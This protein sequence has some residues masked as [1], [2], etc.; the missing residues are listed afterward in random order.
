MNGTNFIPA[1]VE[2]MLDRAEAELLREMKKPG[3]ENKGQT[4]DPEG[5]PPESVKQKPASGGR[6]KR[7][8]RPPKDGRASANTAAQPEYP[9]NDIDFLRRFRGYDRRQV[10]HYINA[11][12]ENYNKICARS[13]ELEKANEQLRAGTDAIGAAILKAET[14]A[15]QIIAQAEAEARIIRRGGGVSQ[16]APGAFA[17]RAPYL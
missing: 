2:A 7:E 16:S 14:L 1:D 9:V 5:P 13:E 17:A 6:K 10:A 8:K 3:Q 11:L 12:T 15:R 4:P